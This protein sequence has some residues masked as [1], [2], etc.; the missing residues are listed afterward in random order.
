MAVSQS[1][2]E[3]Q[4]NSVMEASIRQSENK[5]EDN[6]WYRTQ[7]LLPGEPS[8]SFGTPRRIHSRVRLRRFDFGRLVIVECAKD[9]Y[10]PTAASSVE[11]AC[12]RRGG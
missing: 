1:P 9:E 3:C 8:S 2:I 12:A 4:D 10:Q 11:H 6:V 5:S 7:F